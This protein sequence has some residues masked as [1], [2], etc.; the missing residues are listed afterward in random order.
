MI[1]DSLGL[2]YR[3][4]SRPSHPKDIPSYPQAIPKSQ[5]DVNSFRDLT[6]PK[7]ILY[8]YAVSDVSTRETADS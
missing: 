2:V 5:I 3:D 6:A 8:R 7:C 1:S 4:V